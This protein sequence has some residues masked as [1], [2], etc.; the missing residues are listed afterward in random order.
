MQS[1]EVNNAR[2]Q[3]H[4][5]KISSDL[6]ALEGKVVGHLTATS[7]WIKASNHVEISNANREI[8]PA[9]RPLVTGFWDRGSDLPDESDSMFGSDVEDEYGPISVAIDPPPLAVPTYDRFDTTSVS[10]IPV[11]TM[12]SNSLSREPCSQVLCLISQM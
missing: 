5:N 6:H 11:V 8:E 12:R 4:L 2:L 10:F 9:I 3:Q 1:G 7:Q